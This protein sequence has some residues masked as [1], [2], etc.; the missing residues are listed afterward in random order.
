MSKRPWLL[1]VGAVLALLLGL[2]GV[3]S[4]VS[5]FGQPLNTADGLAE[6]LDW[7]GCHRRRNRILDAEEVECVRLSVGVYG[8]YT[9]SNH[10]LL[11]AHRHQA[12]RAAAHYRLPCHCAA[13][14]AR[15]FGRYGISSPQGR[16]EVRR[17]TIFRNHLACVIPVCFWR[18]ST[19]AK[20]NVLL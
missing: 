6:S 10:A 11:R 16:F 17:Q 1:I 7:S 18:E 5:G 15:H 12:N 13:T 4:G 3:V 14:V 8:A 9:H 20:F 19:S 2:V